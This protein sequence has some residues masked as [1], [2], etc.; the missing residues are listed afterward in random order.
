MPE[1]DDASHQSILSPV[2]RILP[3]IWLVLL[4]AYILIGT[5]DVPFHGDESTQIFMSRDY[6][7][8]FIEHDYGKL[9]YSPNPISPTEQ[10]LRLLNGTVNK[11]LIGLAW[12]VNGMS[13]GDINE[14]WDWG[15]DWDYNQQ[16]GHAPSLTLLL[17][18]RWPSALLLAAGVVVMFGLGRALG[19][20]WTPYIASLYYALNPAL[21][22]N[23]R[24]AMM[25]GSFIFFSLMV[26]LVAVWL[27]EKPSLRRAI[28][29]GLVS[30]FA[31][32]SKHTAVFTIAAVFGAVLL[33][34]IYQSATSED[35]NSVVDYVL[36]PYLVIAAVFTFGSFFALNPAWWGDPAARAQTVVDL[37]QELL[38]GQTAVF[39][40]YAHLG[41]QITGFL[42]QSLIVHPQ[43]YEVDAW[44]GYIGDQINLYEASA[45]R[46]VSIG[47][48]VIG[49]LVLCG[50]MAA[51]VWK[52]IKAAIPK[53]LS[54]RMMA[55]WNRMDE[56]S[57]EA[58]SQGGVRWLIGVWALTMI[59]TTLLLT[60]L[61]WQRYYLPVYPVIGLLAALGANALI[62]RI[63]LKRFRRA[64]Y[65]TE[66]VLSGDDSRPDTLPEIS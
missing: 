59:L 63:D 7:Y 13:I 20:R 18:A 53:S 23:G 25:E 52:M 5:A 33:Y 26:V 4:V 1:A 55:R 31:L 22:L 48:S 19:G 57:A 34:L 65:E 37:R 61:E 2:G 49:A 14:Q 27:L 10:Q 51:G 58:V 39:G 44:Q 64:N 41:D 62:G 3:L 24:R 36:L 42:R 21:L 30:G 15:A 50:I 45:W 32:A 46:G 12:H 16:N 66:S 28:L 17:A 38:A 29:L 35:D 40:G 54:T 56:T 47:G 6:A 11:Y 8:Q 60:P 9:E 43:Y